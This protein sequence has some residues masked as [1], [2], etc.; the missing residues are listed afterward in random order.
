MKNAQ[1]EAKHTHTHTH[2]NA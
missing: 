1:N 2:T